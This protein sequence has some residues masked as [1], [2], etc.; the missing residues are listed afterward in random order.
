MTQHQ[1]LY[2]SN[3]LP[4]PGARDMSPLVQ[5]YIGDDR[6]LLSALTVRERDSLFFLLATGGASAYAA[7]AASSGSP[8]S[9]GAG[10]S[11]SEADEMAADL[12]HSLVRVQSF[13]AATSPCILPRSNIWLLHAKRLLTPYEAF[14]LQ[15]FDLE[16]WGILV[17]PPSSTELGLVRAASSRKRSACGQPALAEQSS[18]WRFL[19][20]LAGNSFCGPCIGLCIIIAMAHTAPR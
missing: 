2:A 16:K 11:E 8:G 19:F 9:S 7:Y 6:D 20:D 18:S 10:G 15:G 5:Q 14:L 12:Y 3:S 4:W 13:R 1:Q 17:E